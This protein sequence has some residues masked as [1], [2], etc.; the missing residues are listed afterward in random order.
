MTVSGVHMIT[1][2]TLQHAHK[3]IF[4]QSRISEARGLYIINPNL[5][6][7]MY[8]QVNCFSHNFSLEQH[9]LF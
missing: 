3:A 8:W 5:A 7:F 6:N 9:G 2:V 4:N 1:I